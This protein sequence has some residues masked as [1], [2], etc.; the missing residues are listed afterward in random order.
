MTVDC[1]CAHA[2][3]SHELAS[4]ACERCRCFRFR[5]ISEVERWD[6]EAIE[7]IMLHEMPLLSERVQ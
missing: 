6:Q 7:L 3:E 1:L 5:P 4:G 2:I